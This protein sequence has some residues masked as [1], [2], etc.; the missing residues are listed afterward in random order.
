M[1]SGMILFFRIWSG[2][3]ISASVESMLEE[4]FP[5]YDL[6]PITLWNL[7]KTDKKILLRNTMAVMAEYGWD[8]LF[9][10]LPF[11]TA[12]FRTTWLFKRVRRMAAEIGRQYDSVSFTFQLQ[13]M[14]DTSIAG[15]PN[16]VYTDHT[17]LA[18][19]DYSAYKRVRL[20]SAEWISCEK[21]IYDQAQMVFTWSSNISRS[22]VDQYGLS[23]EKIACV[24]A[25][26][27][28]AIPDVKPDQKD[29]SQKN[30]L[31]VGI[32]WERKGGPDLVAAFEKVY[33]DHPGARLVIVGCDIVSGH[34]AIHSAGKL[35]LEAVQRYFEA[36]TIFCMPT[37][38]EPFGTVF[39]EAMTFALPIVATAIGAIPDMVREGE[40]GFLVAPGNVDALAK[41]LD[42]LL[43]DQKLRER[44]GK[45]SWR[46]FSNH[47]NWQTVGA[48]LREKITES[49]EEQ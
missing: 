6:Q 27:N 33:E 40:N 49:L 14:F 36:A 31:F 43:S 25:G 23:P 9:R 44:F 8:I 41:A 5:E 13:S 21:S 7:I 3:P 28:T 22:L 4:A 47:Y 32:D 39:V 34:P 10:K 35:P 17:H 18:N 26:P 29:Y 19:L 2:A 15:I 20:F 46:I 42:R 48:L 24:F 38:A 30:I 12:F 37:L 45:E 1:S 11:K 16:F